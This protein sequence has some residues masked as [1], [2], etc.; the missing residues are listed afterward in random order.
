MSSLSALA[1]VFEMF[2]P[3]R[4]NA[5]FN[6]AGRMAW[7]CVCEAR[8]VVEQA[9]QKFVNQKEEIEERLE[10]I[11]IKEELPDL[12]SLNV[13]TTRRR[14]RRMRTMTLTQKMMLL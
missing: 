12:K 8:K 7:G 6:D 2:K 4:T 11:K 10:A 3:R 14:R 9:A 13:E 1:T 5:N